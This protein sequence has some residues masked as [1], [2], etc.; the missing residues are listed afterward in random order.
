MVLQEFLEVREI[1][2][3]MEG[4]TREVRGIVTILNEGKGN[5]FFTLKDVNN[6]SKI[7]C[8]LFSKTNAN[9]PERKAML[10]D[11]RDNQTV[12]YLKGKVD[13]YKGELE[14]KVWQVFKK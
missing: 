10:L 2:S 1:T 4:N 8:V 3:N 13:V 11:S 7:K 6:N 14:I 5:V 9:D 12:I